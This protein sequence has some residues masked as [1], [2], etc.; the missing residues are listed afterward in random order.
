MIQ[1]KALPRICI[2]LGLPDVGKLL[3]QARREAEAGETFLEFRLDY[4]DRPAEGAAAIR[5]F[6]AQFPDCIVLATCRRHQNHGRFNGSIEEQMRILDLAVQLGAHAVD[7]EVETAEAAP[8]KLTA[9]RSRAYLLISY[10]NYEATPQLDQVL[11][12][13]SRIPADGYK[14]VT[15]A[16]VAALMTVTEL[17]PLFTT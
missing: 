10:H 4:L 9:F 1:S 8:E 15:T 6:L 7:V 5:S 11:H 3:G 12:R 16:R 2:A 14:V 13:M 17:P